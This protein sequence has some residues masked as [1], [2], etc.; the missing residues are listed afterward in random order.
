[1][2]Q[3]YRPWRGDLKTVS[4]QEGSTD[5]SIT[6]DGEP[7]TITVKV[8]NGN[9]RRLIAIGYTIVERVADLLHHPT[10]AQREEMRE[11]EVTFVQGQSATLP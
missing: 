1:M 11:G 4:Y 5:L 6:L 3:Q 10:P 2:H 9:P 7:W 8:R